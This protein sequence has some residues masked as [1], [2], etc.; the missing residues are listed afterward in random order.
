MT[1]NIKKHVLFM[2]LTSLLLVELGL[3]YLTT[4]VA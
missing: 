4:T 3:M 1:T 2:A